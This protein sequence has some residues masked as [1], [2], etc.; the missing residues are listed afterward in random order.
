[1]LSP[2]V[3]LEILDVAREKPLLRSRPLPANV[4]TTRH[5]NGLT[6]ST[7][8][9][10]STTAPRESFSTLMRDFGG[11]RPTGRSAGSVDRVVGGG[12]Q[13]EQRSRATVNRQSTLGQVASARCSWERNAWAAGGSLNRVFMLRINASRVD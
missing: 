7:S 10:R 11:R 1:M 6:F 8:G 2:V 5:R 9:K 13:V 3:W 12:G 4:Y